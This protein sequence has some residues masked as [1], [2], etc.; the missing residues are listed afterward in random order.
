[1]FDA[2]YE[3]GVLKPLE[4]LNLP[5]RS[6]VP[7]HIHRLAGLEEDAVVAEQ[8]QAAFRSLSARIAALPPESPADGF[9]GEDHDDVLYG[10]QT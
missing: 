9:S 6:Q 5:E 4:L 3:G 7:G 1:M 8:Q 2:V 10:P